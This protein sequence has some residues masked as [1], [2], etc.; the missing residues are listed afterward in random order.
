MEKSREVRIK[1]LLKKEELKG[2]EVARIVF[3]DWEYTYN[4][5]QE[6]ETNP[7]GFLSRE[8]LQ[9]LVDKILSA[10]EYKKFEKFMQI[11][12]WVNKT[13]LMKLAYERQT[14]YFIEKIK[15]AVFIIGTFEHLENLF[16]SYPRIE[17]SKKYNSF[18]KNRI[19]TI[20]DSDNELNYIYLLKEVL[21]YNIIKLKENPRKKNPLKDIK[22]EYAKK[23]LKTEDNLK[24]NK[25]ELLEDTNNLFEKYSCFSYPIDPTKK[26]EILK[27]FSS[28]RRSF[29]EIF[30][31][32]VEE[33]KEFYPEIIDLKGEDWLKS[34]GTYKDLQAKNIIDVEMTISKNKYLLYE[35][36][37]DIENG[38][39]IIEEGKSVDFKDITKMFEMYFYQL[40]EEE[41]SD[42]L[43]NDFFGLKCSLYYLQGYNIALDLVSD[44]FNI[45]EIK[46]FKIDINKFSNPI[47][48]YNNRLRAIK[49]CINENS[50][51]TEE[52]KEKKIK[53][54]EKTFKDIFI[55]RIHTPMEQ[56]KQAKRMLD[57]VDFTNDN[58]FMSILVDLDFAEL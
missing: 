43:E 46:I 56:I 35:D 54:L 32:L 1:N 29:K 33:T 58:N 10:S 44:H 53:T 31:I 27:S 22:K 55:H 12:D 57:E 3:E 42:W 36:K 24:I 49:D 45:P 40:Q 38:V 7:N 25:W 4:Q 21:N 26:E 5:I 16:G 30:T 19:K 11:R 34:I 50:F 9:L 6:E 48:Q 17:N 39:A 14:A 2:E 52:E 20:I 28:F 41:E 23:T 13:H 47:D 18:L 37:H 8:T 15:N 51:Y